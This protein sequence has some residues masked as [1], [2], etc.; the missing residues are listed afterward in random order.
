MFLQPAVRSD[1]P[2]VGQ[3]VDKKKEETQEEADEAPGDKRLSN[4]DIIQ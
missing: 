4:C 3:N 2:P 1:N